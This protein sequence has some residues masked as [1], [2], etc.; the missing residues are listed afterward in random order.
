MQEQSFFRGALQTNVWD[1]IRFEQRKKFTCK[2][3]VVA[4][5]KN[6]IFPELISILQTFSRF[7]KLPGQSQDFFTNSRLYE[8]T[9]NE[10]EEGKAGGIETCAVD[11]SSCK[12][13]V[14]NLRRIR[15]L[16]SSCC[17]ITVSC[18][19]V[20]ECLR[21]TRHLNL[22]I[23][24]FTQLNISR[25]QAPVTCCWVDSCGSVKL[26]LTQKISTERRAK[27]KLV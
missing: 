8:P 3:L 27:V 17:C 18:A 5:K 14:I 24:A 19:N 16:E 21:G 1:W 4:L 25:T 7:G 12:A 11:A 22:Q 9:V 2:A 6:Q 26:R 15:K 23:F 10:N 13:C 20:G